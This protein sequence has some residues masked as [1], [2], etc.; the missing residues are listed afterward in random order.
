MSELTVKL[1]QLNQCGGIGA[2]KTQVGEW[3]WIESPERVLCR[4]NI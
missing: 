4:T 3:N 1:Y 2:R